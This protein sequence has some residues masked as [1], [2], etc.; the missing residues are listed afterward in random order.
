MTTA[1]KLLGA[2]TIGGGGVLGRGWQWRELKEANKP[3]SQPKYTKMAKKAVSCTFWLK[4]CQK[5]NFSLKITLQ[6]ILPRCFLRNTLIL[7][8]FITL[9]IVELYLFKVSGFIY[10]STILIRVKVTGT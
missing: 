6:D 5:R 4:I 8:F 3:P 10:A 2:T 1:H 7:K 9:S